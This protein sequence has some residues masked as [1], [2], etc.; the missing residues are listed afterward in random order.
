MAWLIT[1]GLAFGIAF[2]QTW[3][4]LVSRQPPPGRKHALKKDDLLFWIDW[5]VTAAVAF[6]VSL[7]SAIIKNKVPPLETAFGAIGVLVLGLTIM[8]FGFRLVSY[9]DHGE[10]KS[11][12]WVLGSNLFALGFLSYA[13]MTGVKIYA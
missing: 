7:I 9:D 1:L 3:M 5:T 4:K 12:W 10:L 6:A 2:L 11:W 13:V 8:P